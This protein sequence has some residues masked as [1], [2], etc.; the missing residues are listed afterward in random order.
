MNTIEK[1]RRMEGFTGV[2]IALAEFILKNINAVRN[3]SLQELAQSAYVSKPSA[4]RL[5][6]KLGFKN[7]REFSVALQVERIRYEEE[8]FMNH[9]PPF[10][11]MSNTEIASYWGIICKNI[12]GECIDIVDE[13]T[14]EGI[15]DSLVKAEKIYI[16]PI[17]M[18]LLEVR[19]FMERAE[20]LGPSP[21]LVDSTE[22]IGQY[23]GVIGEGD[24]VL[25][26]ST[27]DRLSDRDRA[28]LN[29]VKDSGVA[30]LCVSVNR[31]EELS[32]AASYG[33]ATRKPNSTVPDSPLILEMS[34]LLGLNILLC[35]LF[36][37]IRA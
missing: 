10:A 8:T 4:I 29:I 18:S 34:L 35:C 24:A 21:V 12:I 32:E 30:L 7:Y 26:A 16:Y 3:M 13:E 11:S 22:D 37:K 28:F 15:T 9:L 5:Y 25:V 14:L 23:R 33:F 20:I 19:S 1:L 31:I 6:R 17:G 2:E 27:P 36:K